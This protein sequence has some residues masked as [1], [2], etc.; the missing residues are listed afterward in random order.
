MPTQKI[1]VLPAQE[2]LKELLNL[3]LNGTEIVLTEDDKPVARLVPVT[4]TVAASRT[5][6]L[7]QG[8]I[9]TSDDFDAPLAD[10]F[11]LGF[12]ISTEGT[13]SGC[14]TRNL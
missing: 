7:H 4:P 1:E 10:E 11:W 14:F 6:G 12:V 9:W 2:Y 13:R 5:P 8:A 3:V